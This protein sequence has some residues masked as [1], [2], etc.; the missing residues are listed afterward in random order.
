MSNL[1]L[2]NETTTIAGVRTIN[3]TNVFSSDFDIYKIVGSNNLAN[4]STAT[5]FNLRFLNSSD[6]VIYHSGYY[7]AQQGLK[8]NTSFSEGRSQSESRIWNV[9]GSL[10]DSGQSS[11][12]VAY[13]FNPVTDSAYTYVIYQSTAYPSGNYRLYKGIAVYKQAIKITGFQAELNESAGEFA[14][15]GKIRTYGLRVDSS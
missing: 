11:G 8:G 4:N 9:F 2:I 7:Y 5:G 3:I 1:R 15:G 6:S 12:N 13:I 10:D 14:S